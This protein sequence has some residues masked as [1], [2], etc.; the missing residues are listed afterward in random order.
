MQVEVK[1]EEK[2]EITLFI[3]KLYLLYQIAFE[4]L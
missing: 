3:L 1:L 4:Y 2:L